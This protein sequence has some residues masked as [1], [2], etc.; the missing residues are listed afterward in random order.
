M[1]A[2]A[3]HV[4]EVDQREQEAAR[5]RAREVRAAGD[6]RQR[7]LGVVGAE[8]ADDGQA[9]LQGLDEVAH[10]SSVFWAIAIALLAAG[11]PA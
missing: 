8:R 4:A 9:A 5:G 3:A 11:T 6:V 1:L 2:V 7:Q 10:S